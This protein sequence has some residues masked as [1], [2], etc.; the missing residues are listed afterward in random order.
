MQLPVFRFDDVSINTDLVKLRS[1]ITVIRKNQPN[2]VILL[3]I[4]PIV[5]GGVGERAHPQKLTAMSTLAPYYFGAKCGVPS[6]VFSWLGV[7]T[8]GHGL[9]H[10]DHRLLGR[11]AQEMSIVMSCILAAARIFVPPYNK[12]NLK[13][14]DICTANGLILVRFEVGWLHALYN[15]F[16]PF[17]QRFY[18]HP[19]DFTPAQLEEWFSR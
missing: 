6:E 5:F 14:Q 4:S 8:A 3:A 18:C 12:W 1:L 2:G 15:P 11:R 13:T 16:D 19:Y 10:V 9:A 17:H 7:I